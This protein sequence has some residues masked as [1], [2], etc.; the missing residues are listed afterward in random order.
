MNGIEIAVIIFVGLA[1]ISALSYIIYRKVKR[2]SSCCGCGSS[3]SDCGGCCDNK[4][5]QRK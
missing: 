4:R 1:F 2:K 3:C 5:K